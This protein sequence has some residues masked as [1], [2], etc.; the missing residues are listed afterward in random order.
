MLRYELLGWLSHRREETPSPFD[1]RRDGFVAGEGGVCFVLETLAGARRRGAPILAEIIGYGTAWEPGDVRRH[2]SQG[3]RLGLTAAL[4]DAGTRPEDVDLLCAHGL[5]MPATDAAEAQAIH[6]VF[7]E[8]AER[9]PVTGIKPMTG[10][11]SAAA[12]GL[13]LAA[14]CLTLTEGIIPPTLNYRDQDRKCRLNLVTG[15]ARQ[16]DVRVAMVNT[17]S[18]GGQSAA[19][20]LRSISAE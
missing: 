7:G 2:S 5:G 20:V 3:G 15:E 16:A 6:A 17:F 18:F 13:E 11:V 10:H 1:R 14:C 8:S 19:L 12:G 4:A 9:L